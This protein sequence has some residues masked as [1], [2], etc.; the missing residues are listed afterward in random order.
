MASGEDKDARGATHGDLATDASA[1]DAVPRSRSLFP[2]VS[3]PASSPREDAR[4]AD[5]THRD[6]TDTDEFEAVSDAAVPVDEAH[7]Y[8]EDDD[9]DP[10]VDV[11]DPDDVEPETVHHRPRSAGLIVTVAIMT[12]LLIAAAAFVAYLWRV[13]EAWELRVTELTQIGYDL[14]EQLAAERAALA[15]ANQQ[16]DL[17]DDQLTASKDTVLR[18]QAQNA[19]WGD[20]AA[21]AQEQILALEELTVEASSVAI[22][23]SR[24][25]E[26]HEQLVT[27]LQTP[28]DYA[29][30]ELES[31]RASVDELCTAATDAHLDFQQSVAP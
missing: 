15:E 14:G 20:D 4:A 23:L 8:G 5:P 30:E 16:I 18:L 3:T 2:P 28:D 31:F 25:I 19:Q 26:G 27:Y 29:P 9:A 1:R 12:A 6:I 13:S 21:Y 17:L 7:R 10:V 24:C 22:S 11:A